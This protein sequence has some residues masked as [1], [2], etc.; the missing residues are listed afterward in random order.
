[1]SERNRDTLLNP[2]LGG[3]WHALGLV[4]LFQY[5]LT[6]FGL[7][8][9]WLIHIKYSVYLME[10]LIGSVVLVTLHAVQGDKK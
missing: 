8:A 1:M 2:T 6:F 10:K 5:D 7:R 4:P 9:G 3:G